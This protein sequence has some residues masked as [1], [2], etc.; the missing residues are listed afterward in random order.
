[1]EAFDKIL[2]KLGIY[3][4]LVLFFTGS[5]MIIASKYI[6]DIYKIINFDYDIINN[7]YVFVGISYLVGVLFQET[8]SFISSHILYPN[9]KL[10]S[11]IFEPKGWVRTCR[12]INYDELKQIRNLISNSTNI[13]VNDNKRVYDYCKSYYLTRSDTA[14]ID[15]DQSTA[16]MARSFALYCFIWSLIFF[17][18]IIN[19]CQC[20]YEI[21]GGFVLFISLFVIMYNRFIKFTVLRYEKILLCYLN[22]KTTFTKRKKSV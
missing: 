20:S 6:N 2:S 15:R 7:V 22:S 1:M 9:H 13:D 8:S 5:I 14:L 10:F 11:R 19:M 12:T 21:F 17:F 4:I 16:G 18:L 3:D